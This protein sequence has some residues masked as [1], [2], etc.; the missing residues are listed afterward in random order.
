MRA[1]GMEESY[2]VTNLIRSFDFM[3]LTPHTAQDD[4]LKQ[5]FETSRKRKAC[6][7]LN[8]AALISLLLLI[9]SLASDTRFMPNI[10]ISPG[11]NGANMLISECGH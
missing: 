8:Y 4:K 10:L 1:G 2:P 11:K 5:N 3:R 6:N 7:V 9:Q